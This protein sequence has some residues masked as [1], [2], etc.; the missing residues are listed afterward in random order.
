MPQA[1]NIAKQRRQEN[2]MRKI[3]P[4]Y[5]RRVYAITQRYYKQT[6]ADFKNNY[7]KS[8]NRIFNQYR[9][10]LEKVLTFYARKTVAVFTKEQLAQFK[11]A[12]KLE[13]KQRE[14]YAD[15]IFQKYMAIYGGTQI[16]LI[17]TTSRDE[18]TEVLANTR[19][20]PKEL[21]QRVKKITA[22]T[23]FR[24]A[25]IARTETHNASQ[26]AVSEVAKEL[27]TDTGTKFVKA[28]VAAQD[29]R[30]REGHAEQD[31]DNY[32][33]MHELFE[34]NVYDSQGSIVAT[35]MMDR[36]GDSSASA[37]NVIN[38]RC[39]LVIEEAEFV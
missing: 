13:I 24:A 28:W 22:M 35:D 10:D 30:T 25:T 11:C 8:Q 7:G 23:V 20:E 32:I 38:C 2:M 5:T 12:S 39:A 14:S 17:S 9:N 6:I 26:Y 15:L 29:E 34:V 37:A 3:E 33:G 31:A 1:R 36:P 4:V 18:I 16:K 27:E 19:A 21:E